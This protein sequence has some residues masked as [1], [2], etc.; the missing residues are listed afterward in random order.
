MGD[1]E[2]HGGGG[3][4]AENIYQEVDQAPAPEP[5][6][7]PAPATTP[8]P[9][10]TTTPEPKPTVT[11]EPAPAPTPEPEPTP[12][13][14]P[15]PT[16]PPTPA[17]AQDVVVTQTADNGYTVHV[18][19]NT[20]ETAFV[21]EQESGE[22]SEPEDIPEEDTAEQ[23]HDEDEGSL[24]SSVG[25]VKIKVGRMESVHGRAENGDGVR[26][27]GKSVGYTSCQDSLIRPLAHMLIEILSLIVIIIG[28]VLMGLA[29]NHRTMDYFPVIMIFA[30]ICLVN[31]SFYAM[32]EVGTRQRCHHKYEETEI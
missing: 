31:I 30:V 28:A 20:Q 21:G 29:P 24:Q 9:E 12:T 2:S 10:P 32:S 1:D 16:P 7:A 23:E 17:P 3:G 26:L 25:R 27:G 6:P 19:P 14:E 18:N 22:E 8:D 5:V 11:P 4:D 15:A 13:P